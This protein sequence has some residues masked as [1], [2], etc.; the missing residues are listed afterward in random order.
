MTHSARHT[1]GR[2]A[3][4]A[5]CWLVAAVA[6]SLGA[7]WLRPRF[8]PNGSGRDVLWW[9]AF[10]LLAVLPLLAGAVHR[11]VRIVAFTALF[12]SL[13]LLGVLAVQR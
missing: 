7:S 13:L 2:A 8:D 11:S 5:V 6:L 4:L 9:S 10:V 3:L 1:Y 12:E